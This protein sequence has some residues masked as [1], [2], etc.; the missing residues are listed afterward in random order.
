[1]YK[2]NLTAKIMNDF[3]YVIN[4][5]LENRIYRDSTSPIVLSGPSKQEIITWESNCHDTSIFDDYMGVHEL[6]KEF[7]EKRQFSVELYDKSLFQF[8]CIVNNNKVEKMRML[9]VKKDNI[10][11]EFEQVEMNDV[12]EDNEWFENI[13]GVPILIRIDYDP[14]EYVDMK[15]SKAHM[16]LSNAKNCRIPMK[17]FFMFSDFVCFILDNFYDIQINKN[18]IK[19][20]NDVDISDSELSL[21]HINWCDS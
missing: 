10:T 9:F 18:P 11:W 4:V 8:E 6:L 1:M 20:N 19:Y 16:T 7:L 17:T 14:E 21:F 12:N 5:L 15:H 2:N 3:D 13:L